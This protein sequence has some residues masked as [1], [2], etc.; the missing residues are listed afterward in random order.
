MKF[1]LDE[2]ISGF[3]V[4]AVHIL[5]Q[6]E[7]PDH[8]NGEDHEA[9]LDDMRRWL[10]EYNSSAVMLAE[11]NDDVEKLA[12]YFGDGDRM[13]LMFDF[14]TNQHLFLA[15]A[16]NTA[17]PLR[18]A[19]NLLFKVSLP[20]GC[21]YVN[22]IRK[23]DELNLGKLKE[24]ERNEVFEA[25]APEDHCMTVRILSRPFSSRSSPIPISSP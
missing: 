11:A 23:H 9:I 10:N 6:F 3:R 19:I 4:D 7:R 16:R 1:W 25:F 22:F 20:P 13:H 8:V 15:L 17:Q 18:E 12:R 5:I 14:I 21:G 2:G 24:D